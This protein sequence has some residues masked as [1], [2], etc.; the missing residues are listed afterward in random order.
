ME[1]QIA[2]RQMIKH[3]IMLWEQVGH[4]SAIVLLSSCNLTEAGKE[5]VQL[6][7]LQSWIFPQVSQQTHEEFET[8]NRSIALSLCPRNAETSS[9]HF[10]Y[11]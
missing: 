7:Y 6:G 11:L 9:N 3:T 4:S 1:R 10:I 5:A 2:N 8:K